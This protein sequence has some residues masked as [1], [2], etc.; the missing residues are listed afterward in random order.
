MGSEGVKRVRVDFS[1]S[2]YDALRQLADER[3]GS[4]AD[5]LRDAIALT[6][7]VRACQ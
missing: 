2:T 6:R 1:Q 4:M 5:A 7:M 3:N